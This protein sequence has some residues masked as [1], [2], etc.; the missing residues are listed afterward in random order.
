[1]LFYDLRQS[2]GVLDD[3]CDVTERV[4]ADFSSVKCID[5]ALLLS[6]CWLAVFSSF[7]LLVVFSA[8]TLKSMAVSLELDVF[9]EH[10]C[11]GLI[12]IP[13]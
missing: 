12:S 2:N 8:F 6:R 10:A 4:K 13:I 1:M 3:E 9:V 7:F 11:V 5:I